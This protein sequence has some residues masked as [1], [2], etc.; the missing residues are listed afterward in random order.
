MGHFLEEFYE[1]KSESV[2][3]EFQLIMVQ[4]NYIEQTGHGVPLIVSRQVG[5][6]TTTITKRIHRL[7][8]EGIVERIGSK[9][10]GPNKNHGDSAGRIFD[11]A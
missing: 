3:L 1:G 10:T 4:M 9:K 6:G 8:E 5:L 7:K 11:T 2:N